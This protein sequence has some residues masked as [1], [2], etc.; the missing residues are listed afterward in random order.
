MVNPK[1]RKATIIAVVLVLAIVVLRLTGVLTLEPVVDVKTTT[2]PTLRGLTLNGAGA[3]FP[4]PQIVEW[5]RGFYNRSGISI[6]YQP[7]GSGAGLSQ[8]LQNVTD[9]ACSDPP[10]KRG[11]WEKY[12]GTVMQVPWVVGAVVIVYNIPEVPANYNLRLTGEVIAKIYRGDIRF[13]DDEEIKKLNT[14][15]ADRLPHKEIVAVYRSDS[16]G[17]TEVFTTF[18]YKSAPNVWDSKLVGKNIEWPVSKVGRGV[19]GQGNQGVTQVVQT[20]PYSIGYVEWSFA[21]T[22]KLQVAAVKNREGNYVLPS[23]NA[24]KEALRNINLPKSPLDD[25]SRTLEETIYA[26]GPNSYP[27]TSPSYI[28]LWRSYQSNNKALAMSE[29]LKWVATEGYKNVVPGYVAPPSEVINLLLKAA[30]ILI[31]K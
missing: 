15:I 24:L 19:G 10:L 12:R 7:V 26:G 29:F 23:E 30:E 16:S 22:N 5:V 3:T 6:N 20:T 11:D 4:Y 21:I 9:F 8:F 17:T 27:I 13:W 14:E 18:L 25:F 2:S 31:S 1:V 28:I